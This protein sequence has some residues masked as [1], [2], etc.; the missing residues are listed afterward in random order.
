MGCNHR[1]AT[2]KISTQIAFLIYVR[3]TV[4]RVLVMKLSLI[5]FI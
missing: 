2:I 5:Y 1:E 4:I 3:G